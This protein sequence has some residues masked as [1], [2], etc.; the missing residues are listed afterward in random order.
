MEQF[1]EI[2]GYENYSVINLGTVKNNKTNKI[3]KN[4]V[5]FNGYYHVTLYKPNNRQQ[6]KIHRLVSEAFIE[7]PLNKRCIDHKDNNKSNNNSNNL[8]WC[9]DIENSQNRCIRSDNNSSVKGVIFN[10]KSQKWEAYITIDCVR[11]NLGF[12][13]N[14]EDA[15]QARQIRANE[16]FGC[17]TNACE[18][19]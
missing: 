3:L 16:A 2:E 10:K 6:F 13:I 19:I 4:S 12:Y 17:Y 18:K 9:T 5:N 15:K 11:V 8:R 7:N 14:F 1:R